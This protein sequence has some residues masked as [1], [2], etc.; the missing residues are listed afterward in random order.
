MAAG[1]VHAIT[2][3]ALG[4][5][6][7][8]VDVG[9]EEAV[10]IDPR[11][12]VDEYLRLA[13]HLGLR[14]V[15]S[16]E[17]HLHADFVSGSRELTETAGVEVIAPYGADLRFPHRPVS[18]GDSVA[19]GDAAFTVLHTPGH[20]PEHMAYLLT[21]PVSAVFSGGSLIAGGAYR[22]QPTVRYVAT[23]P[24]GQLTPVPPMPQ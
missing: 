12:D 15:A 9:R 17:T 10:V 3:E 6:S 1:D 5:T 22:R 19:L 23:R 7:Y 20:T 18:E 13:E 4:N 2:D 11:R 14:I 8:V 16:L 24:T 21:E